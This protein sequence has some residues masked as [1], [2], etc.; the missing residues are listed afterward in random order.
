[1]RNTPH[2][3]AKRR[4]EKERKEMNTSNLCVFAPLREKMLNFT[5]RQKIIIALGVVVSICVIAFIFSTS[6]AEELKPQ[7]L[8]ELLS[9]SDK[10]L[11]RVDIARMNLL[12]A[13]GLPGAEKINVER[14]LATLDQWVDAL[15]IHEEKM[16]YRFYDDPEE[17]GNSLAIFKAVAI[18]TWIQGTMLDIENVHS[19]EDSRVLFLHGAIERRKGTRLSL[20]F[21]S[22]A[23][24]RRCGYP[25]YLVLSKGHLFV[26][27][28]DGEERF[29][30]EFSGTGSNI[31]PDERYC[32]DLFPTTEA[33]R[34]REKYFKS[35]T[36]VEELSLFMSFR[37]SCF[38]VN[39]K[40]RE[41]E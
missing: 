12:C 19:V 11:E 17:Y 35:L 16:F 28:D 39:G 33:E 38:Q 37:G 29:N 34:I 13:T 21:L 31:F 14:Y 36:P 2:K 25:L 5:K 1:M 20:P 23:L 22:V 24:G 4:K 15:R 26:R 40:F 8:E 27:W 3:T 9:L 32:N 41:A 7:T 18:A 6:K 10:D 30:F